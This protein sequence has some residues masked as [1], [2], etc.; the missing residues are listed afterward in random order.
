MKK[1]NFSAFFLILLFLFPFQSEEYF[2][3]LRKQMVEWQLKSR[4]IADP[5][6]LEVMG[7]VKRHLF[8][9][10]NL[11]SEAYADHPLPI[12]EGQTISQPYIVALMTQLL[13]VKLGEKVL[14]IGTGSGYQAAVLAELTDSV[15]TIE[16]KEKLAVSAEKRLRYLRYYNIK[17]KYGDG[18]YGWEEYAPF[19]A[20]II[21]A[22]AN[23]IPPPLVK[24]LKEGGRL[25]LP[26]GSTRYWQTLTMG[27]KI[28]GEL[29]NIRHITDVIF[30]PMTGEILKR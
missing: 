14:E 30:V 27:T 29:T 4:D 24:Q 6:V 16:I 9:S 28:S 21:T 23:H 3:Q 20:I 18:Y 1:I 15:Y 26:L 10:K 7:K 5:K 2:D 25:L 8:V 11:R 19:D 17:V 12:G 13:D 22:A